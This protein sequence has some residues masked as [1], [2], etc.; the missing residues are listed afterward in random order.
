MWANYRTAA[1]LLA[2]ACLLI[3]CLDHVFPSFPPLLM[4]LTFA[5]NSHTGNR[6]ARKRK[7]AST[8]PSPRKPVELICR[9]V[10]TAALVPSQ[11]LIGTSPPPPKCMNKYPCP[12]TW[13]PYNRL[14]Q[15]ELPIMNMFHCGPKINWE[16]NI[17]CRPNACIV[18]NAFITCSNEFKVLP[19]T[20][21][22]KN[23]LMERCS[24]LCQYNEHV[25]ARS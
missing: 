20:Q 10:V 14:T 23:Q 11:I 8:S 12:P 15:H 2:H 1:N 5:S 25:Q 24:Q 9:P 21:G 18:F 19:C 17:H 16:F 7:S 13:V 4:L 3:S 6:F 22:L